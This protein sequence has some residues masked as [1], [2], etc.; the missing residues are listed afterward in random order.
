MLQVHQ[1]LGPGHAV[2]V[3]VAVLLILHQGLLGAAAEDAVRAAGVQIALLHQQLLHRGHVLTALAA[4]D[5][6][7][8]VEAL[9]AAV[10]AADLA[11][12]AAHARGMVGGLQGDLVLIVVGQH[13][14]R[15]RLHRAADLAGVLTLALLGAGRLLRHFPRAE[16]VVLVELL[17]L[18]LAADLAGAGAGALRGAGG[19]LGH[20]PLGPA[21]ILLLDVVLLPD[22]AAHA[23]APA[24]ALL[25]AGGIPLDGPLAILM[26]TQALGIVIH[27][28]I[29][30]DPAD[31]LAAVLGVLHQ[32]ADPRAV[33]AHLLG[34]DAGRALELGDALGAGAR[35]AV[36]LDLLTVD[37]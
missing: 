26:G 33:V 36:Y 9:L 25:R 22:A 8:G 32:D 17:G 27:Q 5:G 12:L 20:V 7:L 18:L 34:H 3:Q 28:L 37:I 16:A 29:R 10:V 11:D 24:I 23:G 13:V 19:L 2:G 35:F 1:G 14:Q 31:H 15:L 30:R 6:A 21:V 4:A